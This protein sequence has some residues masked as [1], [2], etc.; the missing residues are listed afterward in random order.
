MFFVFIP[1]QESDEKRRSRKTTLALSR[2]RGSTGRSSDKSNDSDKRENSVNVDVPIEMN[3][4][5]KDND[6]FNETKLD[7]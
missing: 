2:Q 4:T 1:V 3:E 7:L 5:K 6:K